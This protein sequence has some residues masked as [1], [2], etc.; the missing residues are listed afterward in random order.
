VVIESDDW[1]SI[2]M[3]SREVYARC[4]KAGYPVHKNPYEKYDSLLS[5]EDLDHLFTVLSSFKDKNGR[6][7]VITANALVANPDFGK[8]KASGFETYHNEPITDTFKRYPKHANSFELWKQGMHAGVLFPQYHGREHLNVSKFMNALQNRDEDVLFGFD[9]QMP[10]CMPKGNPAR[11]NT[12][13]QATAYD[14][15]KDKSDKLNIYL[16]GLKAFEQLF[17]YKS[18]TIIPTNY[19]WS[20]EWNNELAGYGIKAIQT[21]GQLKDYSRPDGKRSIRHQL[22]SVHKTSGIKYLVRNCVFEPSLYKQN[23]SDPVGNCL[24]QMDIAFKLGKPA[25]ITSHRINF[26]GFIHS[27]N[28]TENL[29]LLKGLIR[30]SLNKWP[31]IIFLN[32]AELLETMH[33]D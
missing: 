24:R 27:S 17:G 28:S 31:E 21:N 26:C 18:K 7:P 20:E 6:H 13:V 9:N 5:E 16:D 4:I 10:G 1:G 11:G 15:V 23:I 3:P 8:I 19:S 29:K 12:Y 14:S 33:H 32:S 2:R 25:I 22:G 30:E